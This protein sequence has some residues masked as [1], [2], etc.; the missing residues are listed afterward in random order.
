MNRP[1]HI[2]NSIIEIFHEKL[3]E[4]PYLHEIAQY[5]NHRDE[6][7][8][9]EYPTDDANIEIYPIRISTMVVLCS[10]G[11]DVNLDIFY[12]HFEPYHNVED[13]YKIISLEY[14]EKQ[15]KGVPKQKKKKQSQANASLVKKR[16][17]FYNQATIIMDYIKGINLKL[18]R[19]G[20]IHITGIIDEEQGKQAVRFLG[21]EI[22]K[23]HAKDPAISTVDLN[24]IG[25]YDW[26]IVMIN[27]D[28]A[29]N[30]K[31]RREKLC[32][33]IGTKYNLVVNYESDSYPGVK[34]SFYWNEK[35]KG[36]LNTETGEYNGKKT[37]ICKCK[38]GSTCNGKGLGTGAED[39]CC[40]KITISLFQSGKVIITGARDIVM[41]L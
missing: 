34:T 8:V 21:N 24:T 2:E 35:D 37:G 40:R 5:F 23:I 31:M 39:D 22:K 10:L 9:V 25:V 33:I 38:V 15:A 13:N 4:N 1:V 7:E 26:E 28:F 29:C 16:K 11:V 14:M 20:R 27:S 30:F 19:N 41:N 18:F 6:D 36:T 32:E 3:L 12:E 17:S